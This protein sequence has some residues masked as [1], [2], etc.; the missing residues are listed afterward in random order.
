M[1]QH[2]S[3]CP[4]SPHYTLGPPF[5]IAQRQPKSLSCSTVLY[6]DCALLRS[7]GS[8]RSL[9]T[10]EGEG[11]EW[12]PKGVAARDDFSYG[13][14]TYPPGVPENNVVRNGRNAYSR[15]RVAHW[16]LLRI[17]SRPSIR[18]RPSG[19]TVRNTI[20]RILTQAPKAVALYCNLDPA[21]RTR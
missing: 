4:N 13:S 5:V 12:R 7:A 3:H 10:S 19:Y 11:Q 20:I 6:P 17:R 21:E 16:A 18:R 9:L 8:A 2:H 14:K 15:P 1:Q